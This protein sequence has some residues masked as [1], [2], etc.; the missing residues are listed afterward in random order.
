MKQVKSL[1]R[2]TPLTRTPWQP[3]EEQVA[4]SW[5]W[6]HARPKKRPTRGG[7]MSETRAREI[8]YARSGGHCEIALPGVCFGAAA[9]FHHRK[10]RSQ[11]GLWLPSNGLHTCGSGT[12]GCHGAVTDP[13]GHTADYEEFGWMVRRRLDPHGVPVLVHC[14]GWVFLADDGSVTPAERGA[15]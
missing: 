6:R 9:S 7:E 10:K 12:T 15:A 3:T 14:R 13:Q 2:H 5:A 11:G 1:Q 8:V 4:R